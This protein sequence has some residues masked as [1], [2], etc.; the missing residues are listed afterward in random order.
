YGDRRPLLFAVEQ[1]QYTQARGAFVQRQEALRLAFS[2]RSDDIG[3]VLEKFHIF[4]FAVPPI[5][6]IGAGTARSRARKHKDA[7]IEYCKIADAPAFAEGQLEKAFVNGGLVAEDAVNRDRQHGGA[8]VVKGRTAK[9]RQYPSTS[10][11]NSFDRDPVLIQS[12]V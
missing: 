3:K 9:A 4:A 5:D 7:I 8:S 10:D 2:V 6:G 12:A 1:D 11:C